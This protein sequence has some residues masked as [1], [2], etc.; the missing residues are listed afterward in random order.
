MHLT[1]YCQVENLDGQVL[2]DKLMALLKYYE[3]DYKL[4]TQGYYYI[5]EEAIWNIGNATGICSAEQSAEY[6]AM[7]DW[8][9]DL[10]LVDQGISNGMYTGLGLKLPVDKL[11]EYT[12]LEVAVKGWRLVYLYYW[13]SFCLLIAC[14]IIFL[15]LIRRHKADLFD[16]TSVISRCI[17]LGV[18]GALMALMAND[19]RLFRAIQSPA[20]LPIC[21]GLLFSILVIDKLSAL[22][23]NYRLR[24]SGQPY[25]L[26]FEEHGHAAHSHGSPHGSVHEI[27]TLHGHASHDSV[28]GLED[29]RKSARWSMHPE[30]MPFTAV[31]TEY[32]SDHQPLIS[33]P[34]MSP[35]IASPNPV[36]EHRGA[37]PHGYAPVSSGQNYG[38]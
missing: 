37:G 17:V 14:L 7:E 5:V 26:E 38:A 12:P 13:S 4:E 6:G 31:N 10:I 32:N 22:W 16:F 18:G 19:E 1:R 25:A 29:L 2:Q 27:P 24:K 34:F 21:V 9:M 15:F 23:C 30:N 35:P 3:L 11:E 20:L 8:P 33:P 28:H 36:A